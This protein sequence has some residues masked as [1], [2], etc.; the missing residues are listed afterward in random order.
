MPQYIKLFKNHTLTPKL[1]RVLV[2]TLNITI[3][4]HNFTGSVVVKCAQQGKKIIAKMKDLFTETSD[5]LKKADVKK[6][7]SLLAEYN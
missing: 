4:L 1:Y 7:A 3:L 6:D 2:Y 5:P